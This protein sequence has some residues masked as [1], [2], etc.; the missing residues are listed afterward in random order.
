MPFATGIDFGFIA[1][2]EDAQPHAKNPNPPPNRKAAPLAE[3]T[4]QATAHAGSNIL[5]LVSQTGLEL[6]DLLIIASGTQ[7]QEVAQIV[8]FGSVILGVPLRFT[9]APGTPVIVAQTFPLATPSSCYT[10]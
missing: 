10:Q 9:H 2:G 6:G 4:L 3:Y 7:Q 5:Q 8:G 1:R